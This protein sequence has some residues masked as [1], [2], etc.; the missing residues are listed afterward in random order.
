MKKLLILSSLI[1]ASVTPAQELGG[2]W[3]VTKGSSQPVV[4]IP[5]ARIDDL[6]GFKWFDVE[7]SALARPVDGFRLG[8]AATLGFALNPQRTAFATIGVGGLAGDRFEWS[9]VRPGLVF[10]V[11]VRF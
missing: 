11:A 10:G 8:G 7:L 3:F 6:F 2:A 1:L 4:L 5:V 9:S